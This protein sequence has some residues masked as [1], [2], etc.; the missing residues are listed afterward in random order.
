VAPRGTTFA[1]VTRAAVPYLACNFI[2]AALI[3]AF[4]AIALWLPELWLR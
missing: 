1:D 3:I 4:P 2:A